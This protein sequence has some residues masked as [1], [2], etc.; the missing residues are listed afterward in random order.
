M[1]LKDSK[2][3]RRDYKYMTKLISSDDLL[4]LLQR[5]HPFLVHALCTIPDDQPSYAKA[6]QLSDEINAIA[7]PEIDAALR[8]AVKN[9]EI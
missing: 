6:K 8:S 9:N 1:Y 3:E 4:D 5:C 2:F 7:Y